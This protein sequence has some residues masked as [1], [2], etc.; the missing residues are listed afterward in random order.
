LCIYIYIYIYTH[1]HTY[2]HTYIHAYINTHKSVPRNGFLSDLTV[3]SF[4]FGRLQSLNFCIWPYIHTY[5]HTNQSQETVFSETQPLVISV[6]DGY[7][8]CIFAYGQTGSG[9][10]HTM[11]VCVH[12]YVSHTNTCLHTMV[13]SMQVCAYICFSYIY[14]PTY[15]VDIFACGQTGPGK[16]HTMQ[17]CVHTYG[18][19]FFAHT[20]ITHMHT[21]HMLL[22]RSCLLCIRV[23]VYASIYVYART[24][25]HKHRAT[26]PA[27]ESNLAL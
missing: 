5:I 14:M 25:I 21:K 15:N 10:T 9:K 6:L 26:E 27:V 7:N 3:G 12:T 23:C 11:Q 24:Y 8:V 16:T 20:C 18:Y 2:I 1:T 4:R 19:T 13:I 22:Y 17:V